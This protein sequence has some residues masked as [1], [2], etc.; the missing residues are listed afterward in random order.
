MAADITCEQNDILGLLVEECAEVIQAISKARR[1]G[2]KSVHKGITNRDNI[3]QEVGD[4][5]TLILIIVQKYPEL[6]TEV[7]LQ[8][9]AR[10][11]L[12]RLRKYVPAFTDVNSS[13]VDL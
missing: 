4:V 10:S 2:L 7:G 9:A 13:I 12:E 1:F 11:K 3:E 8:K 5:L 6:L